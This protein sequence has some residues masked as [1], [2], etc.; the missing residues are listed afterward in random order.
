MNWARILILSR[1]G[2]RKRT[3]LYEVWASMR[4]RCMVPT[5]VDYKRYGARGVTI[6]AEWLDEF[7]NFRAWAI[8]S[9]YRKGLT[10]DRIDSNGDYHPGNCRWVTKSEQQ[11]NTRWAV[12]LTVDGVTR[13]IYEWTRISGIPATAINSRARLGWPHREAVFRP[14]NLGRLPR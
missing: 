13:S 14:L 9:G 6:C 11:A 10:L 3:R 8:A 1:T 7:A 2:K 12:K 5:C 4:K